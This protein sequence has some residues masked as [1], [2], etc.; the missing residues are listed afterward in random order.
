MGTAMLMPLALLEM[1]RVPWPR[2]S[3]RGWLG[4]LFLG[5]VASALAYLVYSRVLRELDAG[6]VGAFVNLDPIVGV[7]TAFVI[8]GEV[9]HVG[10]ILGGVAALAGMLLIRGKN[11]SRRSPY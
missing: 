4:T 5:I 8:L 2:P 3:W 10:Q 9:L 11:H 7:A 1:G 6:L